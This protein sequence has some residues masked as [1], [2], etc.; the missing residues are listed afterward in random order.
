VIVIDGGYGTLSEI[1]IAL[2]LNK[3][4]FGL[5]TWD[6]EGVVKCE[7]PAD[8]VLRAVRACHPSPLYRTRQAGAGT[9]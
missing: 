4:V 2:N 7:T 3:L 1:A 8:A 6:I 9:P 5:K